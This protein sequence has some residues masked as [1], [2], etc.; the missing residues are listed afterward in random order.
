MQDCRGIAPAYDEA[1]GKELRPVLHAARHVLAEAVG[2]L[3][4]S[5]TGEDLLPLLLA[6]NVRGGQAKEQRVVDF[7]AF[8]TA[9]LW[10]GPTVVA[11][12]KRAAHVNAYCS[13][14]CCLAMHMSRII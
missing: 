3:P 1:A 11:V 8:H 7:S 13:K 6:G 9:V 12:G 4:D 5:R 10:L 2:C 14:H